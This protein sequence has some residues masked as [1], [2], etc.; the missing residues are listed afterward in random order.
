ML[1]SNLS[2]RES[3][4]THKP[5]KVTS[6][7][8]KA[9]LRDLLQQHDLSTSIEVLADIADSA[10]TASANED[11]SISWQLDALLIRSMLT[12]IQH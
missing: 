10:S 6:Q 7:E 12:H 4:V 3:L 2:T 9:E 1:P 11:E 8:L 5:L